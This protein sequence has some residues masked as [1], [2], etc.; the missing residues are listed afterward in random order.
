MIKIYY[1][2]ARKFFLLLLLLL[3]LSSYH[4][5]YEMQQIRNYNLKFRLL[6]NRINFQPDSTGIASLKIFSKNY[7]KIQLHKIISSKER[8]NLHYLLF[9]YLFNHP[10]PHH[11]HTQN[12]G[13]GWEFKWYL[14]LSTHTCLYLLFSY[15]L[16]QNYNNTILV[17]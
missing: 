15:Q 4:I 10:L 9:N 6:T 11:T 13:W 7:L 1:T 17:G 16:R 3:F 12:K 8:A 5:I 14:F 2:L